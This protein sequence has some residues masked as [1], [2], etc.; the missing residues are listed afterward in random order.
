[1]Y[2]I[3]TLGAFTIKMI[4]LARHSIGSQIIMDSIKIGTME[5]INYSFLN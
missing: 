1:M 4:L 2:Q 3:I 5:C